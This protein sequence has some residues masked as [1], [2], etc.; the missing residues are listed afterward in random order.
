MRPLPCSAVGTEGAV[1]P[2]VAADDGAAMHFVDET[3]H[4]VIAS[5]PAARA[6]RIAR[7]DDGAAVESALPTR[8][9]AEDTGG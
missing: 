8:L 2:G 9:L 6:Y 7:G 1:P 3:L 4:A 5:R